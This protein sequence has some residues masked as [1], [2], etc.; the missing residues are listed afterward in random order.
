MKLIL[1]VMFI[2][3]I[4]VGLFSLADIGGNIVLSIAKNYISEHFQ[5]ELTAEKITGNPIR[6]YTLHN[7]ALSDLRESKD[8]FSAGF[9]T[10]RANLTALLTGNIRLAEVSLG[11]ISMDVDKLISTVQNIELPSSSSSQSLIGASPAFADEENPLPN[12]PLDR[13]RIVDSHFSSQ[14]GVLD[15]REIGV[16]FPAFD[17][18]I[19]GSINGLPLRGNIDMGE[20]AGFTAA[21]RA[22]LYL[23]SGKILATGGLNGERLDFH[24]SAEDIDISEITALYPA[25]LKPHDFAG[26]ADFIADITGAADNPKFS[27]SIDY[28]GTKVYGFPVERLSATLGYSDYRVSVRDIQA[29]ALNIPVQGEFAMAMRPN[30]PLS[31]MVKLDGSEANLSGLDKILGVSEL[32]ALSG[33]VSSFNANISG[34]VNALNGLVNFSAPRIAYDGKALTNIRAQMKL[35]HSDTAN[36]DGKFAFEGANGYLNG[37]I[38][39]VLTNPNFNLTAKIAGLDIK[40]VENMIPDAPQYKLSG[41]ITASVTV[42]GTADNPDITGSLNSPEFSGLDQK[43]MKPVINFAFANKTLTLSKTEGTLNGMPINLNGTIGPLPSGNPNLNL[44]ATITM[45]PQALKAYV[46]DIDKYALKGKINAGLKVQGSVNSPA[47]NL[48]VS[49]PN[50]QAMNMLSAKD[51]E[52]T[53]AMNGDITALERIS[54][55]AAAKSITASG[56]TFYGANANISKNGDRLMLGG[57]NAKSGSGTITGSGT[58]SLSGKNPL[59]FSFRFS[60]LD[61]A[62]LAAT[63]GVDIKGSLSGTLKVAGQNTNP[64]I[65]LN[66]SIPELNAMGFALNNIAADIAGNMSNIELNKLRA[67]VEGAEITATGTVQI[68]PSLKLNVAINGNSIKLE[69]LLKDYPGMKDNLIGTAGLTFTLSGT[70]KNITGKGSFT[71]PSLKAYGLNLT[72]VNLPLSYSGNSFTS[73]GGTA[74]LYGGSAKNTFTINIDTMKFT[75]NLD[76]SGIDV[77]A[78]IQDVSGG[79]EGRIT[80]T[81]KLNMKINGNTKDNVTYSGSGNFSM[82]SGEIT[83]FKWLDIVAKVHRTNGVKYASVNAP[84]TLQTGRLILKSGAIAAANNNDPMYK[85]AKLSQNGTIDFSGQDVTLN[86][87]I[88]ASINYQLINAIQGGSKGGFEALF[89]GG[90]SNFKDGLSTFLSGGVKQAQKSAS[91]GDFRTVNLKVSGKAASPSFSNLKIGPSTLKPQTQTQSKDNTASG[92]L[93]KQIQQKKEEL[94]KK[95]VEKL[96]DALPESVK[97]KITPNT[98]NN[99]AV[100]KVVTPAQVQQKI[101]QTQQN[102]QQNVQQKVQEKARQTENKVKEEV[103]KGLKK[104]LEGLGGLFRR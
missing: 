34:P 26:K 4:S 28:I 85:Y 41:K 99:N 17:I 7:F 82:G 75:D 64:A 39:S 98:Q 50:V 22:E 92:Q 104:G 25:L 49:S 20:A 9:L 80:G 101:Q 12:I 46:P 30:Q 1:S 79:L 33:K 31:V 102:T 63:S 81:G 73:S 32:K 66:A 103:Q 58:A 53:T 69:R 89:K 43:I 29:S 45:T 8:I 67:D 71:A 5:L 2:L 86:L 48:L 38:S 11:G 70:D 6:G 40:R 47:V 57:L 42:K 61:L 76:A 23:G 77:N 87:P 52:L 15:F 93:Q 35:S 54:I 55:N 18:D 14:F 16:E 96:T 13:F 95:A 27:G 100:Q 65:T 56:I 21:N 94:Q 44:N 24:A 3:I 83:G 88:E 62:P 90:V 59:D 97:K 74:K 19:D 36:V 68:T 78:L 84:L 60:N 37:K 51:I 72:G 10:G 91:T